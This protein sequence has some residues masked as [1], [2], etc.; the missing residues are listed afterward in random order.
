MGML[1]ASSSEFE[2]VFQLLAAAAPMDVPG[3]VRIIPCSHKR[4]RRVE[5]SLARQG[6][7]CLVGGWWEI[8]KPK[9]TKEG[10]KQL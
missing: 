10:G 4:P 9:L 8:W 6:Q 3:T 7:T 5:I 1:D 2:N